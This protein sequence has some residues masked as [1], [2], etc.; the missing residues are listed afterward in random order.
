MRTKVKRQ[1]NY[2]KYLQIYWFFQDAHTLSDL[3]SPQTNG[4]YGQSTSNQQ[5]QQQQNSQ[6]PTTAENNPVDLS[7]GTPAAADQRNGILQ[8]KFNV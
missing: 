1:E 6:Q 5:Q 7:R 2:I 4:G 3:N 8:G